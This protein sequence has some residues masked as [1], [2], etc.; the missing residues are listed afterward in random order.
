M[1]LI[2]PADAARLQRVMPYMPEDETRA[3]LG[4]IVARAGTTAAGI[5]WVDIEPARAARLWEEMVW[6]RQHFAAVEQPALDLILSRLAAL[7]DMPGAPG[8]VL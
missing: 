4:R 7:K 1:N 2:T 6:L 5:R 8:P 3:E